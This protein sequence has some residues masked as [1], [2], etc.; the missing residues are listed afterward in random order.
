MILSIFRTVLHLD[1][2]KNIAQQSLFL[3]V[4]FFQIYTRKV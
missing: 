4:Q 3:Q 2:P 1:T